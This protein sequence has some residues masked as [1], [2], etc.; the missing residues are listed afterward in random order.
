MMIP[1]HSTITMHP[2]AIETVQHTTGV[3]IVIQVVLVGIFLYYV[4]AIFFPKR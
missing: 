3:P 4:Y 2:A 1:P